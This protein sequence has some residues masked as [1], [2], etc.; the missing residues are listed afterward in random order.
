M[1]L[2]DNWLGQC[3]V[4]DAGF[5]CKRAAADKESHRT[6][7]KQRQRWQEKENE[8]TLLV[9]N[10][11]SALSE[12]SVCSSAWQQIFAWFFCTSVNFHSLNTFKDGKF[13]FDD[14]GKP[15]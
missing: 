10:A 3:E 7:K 8:K 1:F 11:W 2:G 4:L 9:P 15:A 6:I 14:L 12:M 5:N 13:Q